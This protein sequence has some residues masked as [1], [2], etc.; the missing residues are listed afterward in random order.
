VTRPRLV[1]A[2]R[3][4]LAAVFLYA[5]LIKA[6][7]SGQFLLALIPFTFVPAGWLAP[8]SVLLPLLEIA[9]GT[10]LLWRRTTRLG[11]WLA[12]VLLA[13]FAAALGWALSEGII[14]ACGCFGNDETPS[15]AAMA[16]ALVRNAALAVGAGFIM[17]AGGRSGTLE[18]STREQAK[19]L[20]SSPLDE[21][22]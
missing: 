7:S 22:T 1:L 14:V 16:W 2:C 21:Q 8:I 15:A 17:W 4:L 5:G 12:V 20:R 9:T 19:P 6:S 3:L 13:T 18:G 10:L 11:A